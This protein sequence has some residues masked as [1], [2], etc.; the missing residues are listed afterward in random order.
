MRCEANRAWRARAQA[1]ARAAAAAS[2]V[3]AAALLAGGCGSDGG[4]SGPV[5]TTPPESTNGIQW[6]KGR[7]WIAAIQGSQLVQVDP[8][9]GEITQGYGPEDGLGP[10]DDLVL[11]DGGAF[12]VTEPSRGTVSRFDPEHGGRTV[13]DEIGPQANGITKCADGRVFA[14]LEWPVGGV[15][16]IDPTGATPA[17]KVTTTA[18]GMNS[19]ACVGDDLYAPTFFA[20][21]VI[22]VNRESGEITTIVEG[23]LNLPS[24]VHAMPDGTIVA[25]QVVLPVKLMKVD[26]ASGELTELARVEG[27]IADNFAVGPDGTFYVTDFLDAGVVVISPDG[28]QRRIEL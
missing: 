21:G 13:L 28:T 24:A 8:V 20:G 5:N 10:N 9:S 16:E 26:V 11:V 2:A 12:V 3:L 23:G 18:P 1:R 19:M 4:P 27:M 7:L 17:R 25:L 6:S 14:S 15:F 22:R